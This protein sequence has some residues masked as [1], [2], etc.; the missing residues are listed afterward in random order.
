MKFLYLKEATVGLHFLQ[1]YDQLLIHYLTSPTVAI[2]NRSLTL[3]VFFFFFFF[4]WQLWCVVIYDCAVLV[5]TLFPFIV[6][7][8]FCN[9]GNCS[10][11]VWRLLT[12]YIRS[13]KV[14]Y[15]G[16]PLSEALK[17]DNSFIWFVGFGWTTN[18]KFTLIN[19][20]LQLE[21]SIGEMFGGWSICISKCVCHYKH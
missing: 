1:N 18:Y 4:L 7:I 5:F 3:G 15:L 17:Y 6:I 13:I 2:H 10:F 9:S 21:R 16:K 14:Y 12:K 20:H 8:E 11:L 19:C